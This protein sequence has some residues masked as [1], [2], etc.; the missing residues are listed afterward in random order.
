MIEKK[1]IAVLIPSDMN[2]DITLSIITVNFNNKHGLEETIKSIESQT[3]NDYEHIIIDAGSDD[4]SI[5][6]IKS[7]A[8]RSNH[9]TFWVSE[10]DNGIYD[11]M[12]KGIMHARGRYLNFM[13]SGDR[14]NNKDILSEIDFDGTGYI[15]GD[16]IIKKGNEIEIS[17]SPQVV[18]FMF[19][20]SNTI[21]HQAC[22]I[23]RELFEGHLYDTNYKIIA[24]WI[25]IAECAMWRNTTFKHI[26]LIIAE[27]DAPGISANYRLSWQERCNW[28]D[29]NISPFYKQAFTICSQLADS[30]VMDILML[31]DQSKS[32]KRKVT[33]AAKTIY[34]LS[35]TFKSLKSKIAPRKGS[36]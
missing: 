19:I 32:F 14:L 34:K 33:R 1:D 20:A 30:P 17:A 27:C 8:A 12:N 5:E 22:F 35:K 2:N 18:D 29:N 13:N 6:V 21:C 28:A 25:H 24:D 15:Y 16:V 9:L 4:G 23:S 10:A 36:K 26:P 3:F 7:Y 31:P 11:G